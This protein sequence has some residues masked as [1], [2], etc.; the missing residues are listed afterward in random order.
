MASSVSVR[1]DGVQ[2]L[3][4]KFKALVPKVADGTRKAVRITLLQVETDAKLNCPVDTGRLRS[5]IHAEEAPNGLSGSVGTNVTYAPAIEF[6]TGKSRAQPF[7][8]PAFEKNREE[9]LTNLKLF[10]KLF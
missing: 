8:F 1:L 6:G 2:G 3:L 4:S 10:T 5:S 9:F 7:L